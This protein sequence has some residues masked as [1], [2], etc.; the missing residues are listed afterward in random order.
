[1]EGGNNDVVGPTERERR[2][3]G[4]RP[5]CR[6]R[7]G[8][9]VSKRRPPQ[10]T[11]GEKAVLVL[12]LALIFAAVVCPSCCSCSSPAYSVRLFPGLL[13]MVL[14]RTGKEYSTGLQRYSSSKKRRRAGEKQV[15]ELRRQR[16]QLRASGSARRGSF[17]PLVT[18]A[19]LHTTRAKMSTLMQ[20]LHNHG[21]P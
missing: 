6:H 8:A 13:G 14:G 5:D 10:W 15:T 2:L 21:S 4:Q 7:R 1:V 11:R 3:A 17:A 19:G 20:L 9:V 16:T 12:I 18:R